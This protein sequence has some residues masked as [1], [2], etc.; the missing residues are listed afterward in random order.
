ML[1]QL[2]GPAL[3]VVGA[4]VLAIVGAAPSLSSQGTLSGSE[5]LVVAGSVLTGTVGIT[6]AHVASNATAA[7]IQIPPPVPGG[8]P[9]PPVPAGAA[10]Q[11][12][13]V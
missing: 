2:K 12:V 3:Y 7:A 5:W 11:E 8:L 1:T 9:V 13:T 10:T 6:T 4:V